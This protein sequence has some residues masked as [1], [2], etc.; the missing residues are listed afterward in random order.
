MK[1][2]SSFKVANANWSN[3]QRKGQA[4]KQKNKKLH[5]ITKAY[6]LKT[7]PYN[8]NTSR[9]IFCIGDPH[10]YKTKLLSE[11]F[12]L[13]NL[14]AYWCVVKKNWSSNFAC[15]SHAYGEPNT[16]FIV[17]YQIE[18]QWYVQVTI[19]ANRIL[20]KLVP[21]RLEFANFNLKN[22][23]W[24]RLWLVAQKHI[25]T[26]HCSKFAN[27]TRYYRQSPKLLLN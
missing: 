18:S 16:Y 14:I 3:I 7:P 15:E 10:V 4:R 13:V 21:L 11:Y 26:R 5:I 9:V 1:Y 2:G 20:H 6:S 23:A 22:C 19:T 17:H 24:S 8:F 27:I 12:N 25:Q